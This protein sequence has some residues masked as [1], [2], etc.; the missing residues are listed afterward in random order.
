MK[1]VLVIMTAY[2]RNYFKEQI[3]AIKSQEGVLIK[4]IILW[5]NENHVD[6]DF[7]REYGVEIIKSDINIKY[8]GRFTL[9]LLFDDIEYVAI[10]DDD[11][12][13]AKGWLQNAIRCTD[14]HNCISGQNGRTYNHNT[15]LYEGVGDSGYCSTDT[16]VDLCGHVWVFRS[17][18]TKYLWLQK[19]I[20]YETGEDIQFC[21]ACR[22]HANIP[23]YC[24]KQEP[25]NTGQLKL[26]YGGDEH[27]TYRKMS[28]HN[29]LRS[30]IIEEWFKRINEKNNL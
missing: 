20:S 24:V 18:W 28:N 11:V 23:T 10:F 2:K 12:I 3:E 8:H 29:E 25:H 7:L 15:K 19:Q 22:Y 1:E 9:P 13:P 27:A 4:K 14:E 30:H 21:M 26:N 6:T 5:Q 17:E 16:K